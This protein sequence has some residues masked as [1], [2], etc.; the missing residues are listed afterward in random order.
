MASD[1]NGDE[2]DGEPSPPGYRSED[3]P[4]FS[5]ELR[6]GE[7]GLYSQSSNDTTGTDRRD[8]E[9]D[10][11]DELTP[12]QEL[13]FERQT[14]T[15]ES[16]KQE[17]IKM[18]RIQLL[19]VSGLLSVLSF[20]EGRLQIGGFVPPETV[21]ES[22]GLVSIVGSFVAFTS[23]FVLIPRPQTDVVPVIAR[24]STV[25]NVA[26]IRYP[27]TPA[28]A[29]DCLHW[30]QWVIAQTEQRLQLLQRINAT[31]FVLFFLWLGM[32]VQV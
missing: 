31:G 25:S 18:A 12:R 1:K 24:S 27:T 28:E 14:S 20:V 17:G 11:D 16:L 9:R 2:T 21:A 15:V 8:T 26:A 4:D 32:Q 22:I 13:L 30:N 5:A 23:V 10:G 19:V 6:Y 3:P 7:F 29:D